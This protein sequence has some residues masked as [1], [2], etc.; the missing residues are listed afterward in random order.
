MTNEQTVAP[1]TAAQPKRATKLPNLVWA[2]AI[3]FAVN[4]VIV[5]SIWLTPD[6]NVALTGEGI[7]TGIA[8]EK[9]SPFYIADAGTRPMKPRAALRVTPV[10]YREPELDMPRWSQLEAA[11]QPVAAT[12]ATERSV[13][14][15]ASGEEVNKIVERATEMPRV[16]AAV[17]TRTT[18]MPK[19]S[20]PLDPA[21]LRTTES[22]R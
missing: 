3:V 5:F 22:P 4:L 7:D 21:P 15:Y 17:F 9:P 2:A 14:T 11:I 1:E 12:R 6:L 18:E 13:R 20:I 10:L 16:T 19:R 8:D